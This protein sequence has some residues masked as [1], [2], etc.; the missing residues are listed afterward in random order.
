MYGFEKSQG[1]KRY[2]TRG[3]IAARYRRHPRTISR[4]QNDPSVGF[5]PPDM[6]INDRNYWSD[7]TLD[8]F[9]A[10]RRNKP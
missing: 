7:E 9:D 5:P 2:F 8:A 6:T 4:W 3:L 10:S 1:G